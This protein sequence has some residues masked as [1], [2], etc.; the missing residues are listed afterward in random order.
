YNVTVDDI[1]P[2]ITYKSQ[3]QESHELV[4]D[5]KKV[6]YLGGTFHTTQGGG[7]TASFSFNGTT[8]YIFG[9][10]R[11][12]HGY[13]NVTIDGNQAERFD[14][15]AGGTGEKPLYRKTDLADR[16]HTVVLSNDPDA[17]TVSAVDIDFITWTSSDIAGTSNQTIDDSDGAFTYKSPGVAWSTSTMYSSDHY[18]GTEHATNTNQAN[19]SLLFEGSGIYLYGGTLHD[20]GGFSVQ[21]DAGFPV[22]LNGSTSGYHSGVL[23]YYADGL[24]VGKHT[25]T[26]TNTEAGRW[27]DID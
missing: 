1:Y 12:N 14:G 10:K 22:S 23:L 21:I 26:V 19:A 11:S 18:G 17:G 9:A 13:Y 8:V 5:L 3:W 15:Q 2:L 24:G 7:S 27:L 25:L 16:M 6:H 4:S 20:H